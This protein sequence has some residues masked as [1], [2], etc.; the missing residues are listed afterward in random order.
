[1]TESN[2]DEL[3]NSKFAEEFGRGLNEKFPDIVKV[4]VQNLGQQKSID[5]LL[6]KKVF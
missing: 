3:I 6:D 5:G 1:M 4:L 2:I